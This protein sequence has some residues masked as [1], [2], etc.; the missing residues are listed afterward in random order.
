[1]DGHITIV[2]YNEA[3][4]LFLD[5]RDYPEKHTELLKEFLQNQTSKPIAEDAIPWLIENMKKF[6]GARLLFEGKEWR[7][8]LFKRLFQWNSN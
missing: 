4:A 5:A 6:K 7:D 2:N 3:V 8:F 1:M